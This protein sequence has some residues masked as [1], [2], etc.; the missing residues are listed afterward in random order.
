MMDG[1]DEPLRSEC[2]VTIREGDVYVDYAGS[3]PQVPSGINCVIHYTAAYTHYPL[4]CILDPLGPKNEG[5]YRP[6]HVT[7]PDRSILNCRFPAAVSGR[8]LTGHML[9]T[10]LFAAL[11]QAIPGQIIADSGSAPGLRTVYSGARDDGSRFNFALFA[12]GGMGAR[13]YSDG[14]PCTQY[15]SNTTPGSIEVVE[16]LA[17]LIVWKKQMWEDSAGSGQWRGGHGQEVE[18]EIAA[19]APIRLSVISDR[20]RFPPLGVEG[21][22]AGTGAELTILN[23]EHA[24]P[25]K[26]RT[27][28]QPGDLL[29]IRFPGGGGFGNPK[30]RDPRLIE[31]DIRHGVLSKAAA[32]SVYG[33]DG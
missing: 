5:S 12:N 33:Y 7:A 16:G 18:L 26:G 28:L 27:V 10:A 22:G 32:R 14:L 6:F 20:N 4:K 17:P 13:P 11:G 25:R 31:K 3:S 2:A 8:H 1:F 9:S 23:R 19:Q 15:P 30:D 21:G 24:I 29:R